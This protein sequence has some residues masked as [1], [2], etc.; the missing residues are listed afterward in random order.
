[1]PDIAEGR[2][3]S[4]PTRRREL[5]LYFNARRHARHAR[6]VFAKVGRDSAAACEKTL[7]D[8]DVHWG[9][10]EKCV[11]HVGHVGQPM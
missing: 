6:R 8:S 5:S 3:T 11:G 9:E 10:H 2:P 7:R 1:M 4:C